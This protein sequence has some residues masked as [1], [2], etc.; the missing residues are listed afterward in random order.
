MTKSIEDYSASVNPESSK[1]EEM[2]DLSCGNSDEDKEM[3]RIL[4]E[5][6]LKNQAIGIHGH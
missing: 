5:N 4:R 1:N 3:C 2:S 6:K